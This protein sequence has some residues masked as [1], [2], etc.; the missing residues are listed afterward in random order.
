MRRSLFFATIVALAFVSCNK[1]EEVQIEIGNN[2]ITASMEADT[3][4]T[5]TAFDRTTGALNWIAGDDI[6]VLNAEGDFTKYT[7]TAGAGTAKATFTA[8]AKTAAN[9]TYALHPYS[10][11]TYS[12]SELTFSLPESYTYEISADKYGTA[13]MIA[14]TEDVDASSFYFE[15]LGGAF[16]FTINNIPSNTTYFKFEADEQITG[17]FK[18]VENE[19]KLQISIPEDSKAS[20]VT[21]NF[22]AEEAVTSKTFFIPLPVGTV[23]GFK[24]SLGTSESETW[25]YT[26]TK[27]NTIVRKKLLAMPEVT[28]GESDAFAVSTSAQLMAMI[29]KGGVIT[30]AKDIELAADESLTIPS[31]KEVTL[32]LN[33]KT[34]SQ[35]KECTA[36]HTMIT[37]KGSLTIIGGGTIIFEDL[38]SGPEGSGWGTYLLRNEGE[39]V[40]SLGETGKFEHKGPANF[41]G[42]GDPIAYVIDNHSAGKVE[43]N[44][45][46]ISSPKSRSI[47]N[48]YTDGNIIINGG[49][50]E[51]QVWMQQGNATGSGDYATK[52]ASLTITGG[53]FSPA[54]A[55]GS[56]VFLTNHDYDNIKLSVTGGKFNTKIGCNDPAKEGVKGSVKAGVFTESAKN[57][58]NS[59]LIATNSTFES[60][61]DG[62]YT[63]NYDP[64]MAVVTTLAEFNAAMDDNAIAT[65]KLGADL[66]TSEI[67]VINR[68]IVLNG[69]SKTLTS[70][71]KRA[72]NV[73][74]AN[75]VTI[76]NLTIEASGERAITVIQNSTNVTIDNVTATASNYTI[77]VAYSAPS[78]KVTISNSTLYGKN[79]VNI[80]S[81]SAD[82][83]VSNSIINCNDDDTTEGESYAALCL[84]KD[85]V[86]GKITATGC[87]INVTESSDS[88]KGRN[89]ADDG[90]VTI[91]G[92][93]EGVAIKSVAITY[94]DSDYYHAFETLADAFEFAKDG[95]V[96]TLIRNITLDGEWTPVGTTEAPFK[97]TFDGNGK[98]ISGLTITT[99]NYAG[100]FGYVSDATIKNV[101][102]TNVSVSGGERMAALVGKIFGD[103]VVENCT[104]SGSVEGSDSNTGGIIGEI[105]TG[106][107]QLTNLTNNATVTNTKTSN[108]RAGGVV[109]QVTTNANVT[110]TG[111]KNTGAITTDNGYAGGIVS[112]YQSGTLTIENCS[113]TGTLVGQYKGN[114]LGWYTSVRSITISTESNDF[115]INAI[116]CVDIAVS[117]N[118]SLYGKNYFVNRKA[119]LTGVESTA[120]TFSAIFA[121]NQIGTSPK[122]LWDKLIAFYEHAAKTNVNF[123]GYPNSYWAMF[124]H[125]AGYPSDGAWDSYFDS[126]NAQANDDMKLTKAEFS[127]ASWREKIVYLGPEE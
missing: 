67:L 1:Y 125:T 105:V 119:D 109:G 72:I 103:A 59:A 126:Y 25:S 44:S 35:T 83:T 45:G 26:S 101:T 84:N 57:N 48:F 34:L 2:T 62:I 78:A 38:G 77:N 71:A 86:G 87:T 50:F 39:L 76:Q 28:L 49:V 94:P 3:P 29:E 10:S 80:A 41:K 117:S 98:T 5:K 81:P 31:G 89:G 51:G 108:S 30:L 82:I 92:S 102:L 63:L 74:S 122:K 73:S 6:A 24:I 99:G 97:G 23:D 64:S 116:G 8:N 127:S 32:D 88:E 18:V 55:D 11:H 40:V 56:S 9:S 75:G 37:N 95:D 15:H 106:T 7:L 68:G 46:T 65:I 12:G 115:D 93:T 47:R 123:A 14:M 114:M 107:V 112:A 121:E 61:G 16:C 110:L 69:N 111:C 96:I 91:N 52:V 100:L 118:M 85:A 27:S 36:H 60:A 20:S 120:Q 124:N 66:T 90:I 43:I 19:E 113:N 4:D 42:T 104:V 17:D 33:G 21:I 54:G 22:P 53:E 70:S 13:P 58:T 79:V